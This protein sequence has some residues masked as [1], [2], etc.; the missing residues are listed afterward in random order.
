M[1]NEEFANEAMNIFN[2]ITGRSLKVTKTRLKLLTKLHKEKYTL[3]QVEFVVK[4]KHS[5]WHK[6]KKMSMYVR[7]ETLFAFSKFEGYVDEEAEVD[8]AG[9]VHHISDNEDVE[10]ERLRK[11]FAK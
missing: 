1:N 3:P 7:P 6:D 5:Q 4:N 10:L 8:I 11:L 2:N 9:Q